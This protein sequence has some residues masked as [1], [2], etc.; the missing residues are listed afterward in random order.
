MLYKLVIGYIKDVN[1]EK[2]AKNFV[3][4]IL[5]AYEISKHSSIDSVMNFRYELFGAL[6]RVMT[7]E[8]RSEQS[9]ELLR[10]L[11]VQSTIDMFVEKVVQCLECMRSYEQTDED[12]G[13]CLQC[14]EYIE[15]SY[16]NPQLSVKM[17][18][19]ELGMYPSYV[20]KLFRIKY[21]ISIPDYITRMR[22]ENCKRELRETEKKI[23]EIA[24]DN[25]FLS[26][27]VFIRIFKKIEG[28][29]P[30]MYRKLP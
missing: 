6:H 18:G 19:N 23:A 25:G 17:I 26:D 30:G 21:G 28:I 5:G 27:G 10:E 4:E 7:E 16:K 2:S 20:S 24:D 3:N 22:I 29:T 12:G 13:V 1:S 14:K 15:R 9:G 8:D 11:M